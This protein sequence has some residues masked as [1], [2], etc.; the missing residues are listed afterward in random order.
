MMRILLITSL[1]LGGV[2]SHMS[3]STTDRP[4]PPTQD[5]PTLCSELVALGRA[6]SEFTQ[7]I[8]SRYGARPPKATLR[9]LETRFASAEV[10]VVLSL[11]MNPP[12]PIRD[13]LRQLTRAYEMAARGNTGL[14]ESQAIKGDSKK[15]ARYV[16]RS[17]AG[18]T[19]T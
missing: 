5:D 10:G 13:A 17:C 3:A 11:A 8:R 15:I 16:T 7:A 2:A 12:A 1:L 4:Y 18:V 14:Y 9:S 19:A 6:G